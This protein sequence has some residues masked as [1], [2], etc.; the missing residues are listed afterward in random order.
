MTH[1]ACLK[2]GG[3]VD[4]A[5]EIPQHPFPVISITSDQRVTHKRY[6]RAFYVARQP[7]YYGRFTW[8]TPAAARDGGAR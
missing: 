3:F 5:L 6:G 7:R 8:L 4:V 1:C 2:C